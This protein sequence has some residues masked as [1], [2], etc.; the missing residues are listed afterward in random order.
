MLEEQS[1]LRHRA[2]HGRRRSIAANRQVC[3]TNSGN[4]R[5]LPCDRRKGRTRK[6][7]IFFCAKGCA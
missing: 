2:E 3:I 7:F 5:I 1:R 4:I 6:A